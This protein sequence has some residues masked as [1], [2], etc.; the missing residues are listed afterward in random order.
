MGK[1]EKKNKVEDAA[2][3][4]GEA[5]GKGVKKKLSDWQ[6]ALERE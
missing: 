6:R 2:E 1:E 5:I 3:K 4:T